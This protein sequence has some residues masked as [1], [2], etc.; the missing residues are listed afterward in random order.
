MGLPFGVLLFSIKMREMGL[1]FGSKLFEEERLSQKIVDQVYY[2]FNF[3][4][5]FG[6]FPEY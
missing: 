6:I 3:T 2:S 5:I 4:S 1:P